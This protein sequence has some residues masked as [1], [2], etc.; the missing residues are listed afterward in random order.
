MSQDFSYNHVQ[1]SDSCRSRSGIWRLGS[2]AL[3]V[4]LMSGCASSG[5]MD[6]AAAKKIADTDKKENKAAGKTIDQSPIAVDPASNDIADS[7]ETPIADA[8]KESEMTVLV[9]DNP[10]LMAKAA[11]INA[12]NSQVNKMDDS[13]RKPHRMKFHY[14]FNKH[15][16]SDEERD[17]LLKHAAYL[18][19]HP[20]V[21]ILIN[22]HTDN[23][24]ADEYND[25]L[26]RLRAK[27]AARILEEAGVDEKQITVRGWGSKKPLTNL[28]D[29]AANRR[30]DLEYQSEQMA[31][32]Q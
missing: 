26:S 6:N 27:T 10:E 3:A 9:L 15:R 11:Q 13:P 31:R 28:Q 24:G 4:A 20:D 18:N 25:F 19:A 14:G 2:L 5:G 12:M 8:D 7:P 16:L 23:Y 22:G 32:A 21:T 1:Y 17:L 30:I 29:S